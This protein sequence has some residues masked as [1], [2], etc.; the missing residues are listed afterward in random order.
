AAQ[1]DRPRSGAAASDRAG[2]TT[3]HA[4]TRRSAKR[5]DRRLGCALDLLVEA[6]H[7]H[8]ELLDIDLH[9]N[10]DRLTADRTVFDVHLRLAAGLF[11]HEGQRLAAIGA[12]QL[13]LHRTSPQGVRR[14]GTAT[15]TSASPRLTTSV[16]TSPHSYAA[17]ARFIASRPSI[18]ASPMRRMTSPSSIF[19]RA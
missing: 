7:L 15:V 12:G 19:P 17:I 6:L 18:A 16:A 2:G 13:H 4:R 5:R 11:H 14:S 3:R 1:R 8:V 10:L 9:T